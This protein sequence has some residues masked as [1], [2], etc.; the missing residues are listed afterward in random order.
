[1]PHPPRPPPPRSTARP[2]TPRPNSSGATLRRLAPLLDGADVAF[3]KIDSL[4]R[5]QVVAELATLLHRFDHCILAPAFPFQGRITR[6]G[7]Q[8]ART[9]TGWQDVGVDLAG[10]LAG[11]GERVRLCDA[12]TDAHLDAIV[13]GGRALPGRVLWCGTGGLAGALA[14]RLPVPCPALPRPRL[15]LIGSDHAVTAGQLAAA[16]A[17]HHVLPAAGHAAVSR[18]LADGAAAVTVAVPPGTPR[19]VALGI[20]TAAFIDL[21][22]AVGRPGTLIVSGGET[23]RALC[24]GLAAERLDVDG[25]IEPGV[26]TSVL[27]GGALDG[28]RIVSK[29]G[30]FGDPACLI[31]TLES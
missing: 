4:L 7:R 25:Q 21:L 16:G 28:Q 20:I 11:W 24:L 3:K 19:G 6:H 9:A 18:A 27:R 13:A 29:S 17:R 1:M 15:A 8:L 30:A 26:P 14:D 31:R 2:A 10:G 23:L 12:E 5:G 22:G